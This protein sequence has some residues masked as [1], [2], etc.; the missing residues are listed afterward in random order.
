ME[1][2]MKG[3]ADALLDINAKK[4][5]RGTITCPICKEPLHYSRR[6]NGHVWG[7]CTTENCLNWMQ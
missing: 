6:N 7:K 4:E 3:L 1:L 2:I 5:D